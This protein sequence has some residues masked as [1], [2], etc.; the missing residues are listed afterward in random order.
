MPL[1]E[2]LL[3]I[4]RWQRRMHDRRSELVSALATASNVS[5]HDV[6]IFEV[7]PLFR[8]L[9]A[10]VTSTH[11]KGSRLQQATRVLMHP[12]GVI[13]LATDGAFA[14]PLFEVASAIAAG[15]G[16]LTDLGAPFL[17][18]WELARQAFVQSGLPEDLWVQ[19]TD[20]ARWLEAPVAASKAALGPAMI[21]ALSSPGVAAVQPLAALLRPA[22]PLRHR[23]ALARVCT[24]PNQVDEVAAMIPGVEVHAVRHQ[25]DIADFIASLARP[26]VVYLLDPHADRAIV[27][28]WRALVVRCD[29]TPLSDVDVLLATEG[30][31]ARFVRSTV[32]LDRELPPLSRAWNQIAKRWR[33]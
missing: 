4:E 26:H 3:R 18:P 24:T 5:E 25:H 12:V 20:A 9:T 23:A 27:D 31:G 10:L 6:R 28:Q 8:A 15:N 11:L 17:G 32:I 29:A 33:S 22:V 21:V 1:D 7:E 2:R 14:R 13:E 19:A 30:L 16:V